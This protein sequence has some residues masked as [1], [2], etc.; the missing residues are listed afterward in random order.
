VIKTSD[1]PILPESEPLG[2]K[3]HGL[4]QGV[5][6]EIQP[7]VSE[8]SFS[9]LWSWVANIS[10][11]LSRLDNVLLI[12]MQNTR[13]GE[14]IALPPLS[15]SCEKSAGLVPQILDSGQVDALA[16]VPEKCAKMIQNNKKYEVKEERERADYVYRC[17]DLR[18][19]AGRRFH[20]KR[21]HIKQFLTSY[22]D[23]NYHTLD[24]SLARE[25]IDFSRQWLDTHPKKHLDGL[26]REVATT[27]R[28]LQ[29]F[30]WLGLS[31]GAIVRDNRI[32]AFA[33][34]EELNKDTFVIRAEKADTDF[35]G[36]YQVINQRFVSDAAEGYKWVNREQDLGIPGLRRAK[37]SYCP[38]HLV[39][40][41]R[42]SR[43]SN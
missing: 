29:G 33:L 15:E 40:K 2:E 9:Y 23:A 36:A 28:M 27:E 10:P 20:S 43:M 42:I 31:G 22:P 25:C 16:R 24:S 12:T 30:E 3:H 35:P 39:N 8:L 1:I 14:T 13:K 7:L 41:Y 21:N 5:F 4:L 18:D 38:H 17:E 19:L 34:G 32:V 6:G 37:Q 26:K 11:T